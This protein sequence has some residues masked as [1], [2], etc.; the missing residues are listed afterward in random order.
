MS[1]ARRKPLAAVGGILILATVAVAVAA[2]VHSA[3]VSTPTPPS[4]AAIV[5]LPPSPATAIASAVVAL[6]DTPNVPTTKEL[7]R[8]QI[9]IID[10]ALDAT[11]RL[12]LN[13]RL[14]LTESSLFE[15]EH[16]RID[17]LR[18]SGATKAQMI[19]ALE[20]YASNAEQ[21]AMHA[22]TL[23]EQARGTELAV[24]QAR[25]HFLEAKI[26]LAEEKAR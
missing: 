18:K 15:W 26:W 4:P 1:F 2:R 23:E 20:K 9:E 16:R 17:A 6:A 13:N 10:R 8:Q 24:D 21:C 7:A 5:A 3:R 11:R 25:Y 12:I 22:K 14:G 19:E